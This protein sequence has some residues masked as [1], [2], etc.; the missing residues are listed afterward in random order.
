LISWFRCHEGCFYVK[1]SKSKPHKL[2]TVIQLNFKITQDLRDI[3][4]MQSLVQFLG[5][6]NIEKRSDSNLCDFV[7]SSHKLLY[8]IVL[9]F[10]NNYPIL[11]GQVWCF[12]LFCEVADL[13]N[14]KAT[15][16]RC[17]R[18][19][20]VERLLMSRSAHLTQEGIEKFINIKTKMNM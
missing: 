6:G 19:S 3:Q 14:S 9:L 2:G 10:F 8:E 1:L 7:I 11:G 12:L 20:V 5:C 16:G 18:P 13:I 4:L 17:M 15:T